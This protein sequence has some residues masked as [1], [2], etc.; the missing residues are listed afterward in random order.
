MP[1]FL[2]VLLFFKRSDN[3]VL[4]VFLL[5]PS[6]CFFVCLVPHLADEESQLGDSEARVHGFDPF[7]YF[8]P[9]K[10]K[11]RKSFF[12][13]LRLN[14]ERNYHFAVLSFFTHENIVKEGKEG[15]LKP[16]E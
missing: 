5:Q 4:F 6:L 9:K 12:G 1:V 11:G 10:Q 16:K 8:R 2:F 13:R 15:D 3:F 14:K 7:E